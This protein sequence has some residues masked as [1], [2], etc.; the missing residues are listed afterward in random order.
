MG[1][2][3]V[4]MFQGFLKER[5]AELFDDDTIK[6]LDLPL[7]QAIRVNTLKI[8]ESGLLRRLRKKGV[9]LEKIPWVKNG[10]FVKKAPFS[11]GA[12]PE[13][14]LGYYFMQDPAS[15]YACEVLDPKRGMR[16]LDMAAAPGGKTTY[17]A[18]LMG[19]SGTVISLEISRERMKSLAANIK[20]MGL[21]N[22]ITTRMDALDAGE[23]GMKFDRVL[24]DAPCTGTGT[25]HKNPEAAKKNEEDVLNCTALQKQLLDAGLGVLNKK[26]VMVY[27]TCSVLPEEN[28][29]IVQGAL[30]RGFKLKS[31]EHGQDPFLK[32]AK[33]FYPHTHGT[34]GF[35]VCKI[36]R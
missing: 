28:E 1:I 36:Q 18:Q 34:Q 33:R 27:S 19:G 16:V 10:Y 15:Q 17:M 20:R 31:I 21:L 35:F 2:K 4:I 25:I 7:L 14:L 5:Y 8:T 9:K 12:T 24:L 11:L 6:G 30:E 32:N 26:G 13:Y 23:L 29:H 3:K 22:V